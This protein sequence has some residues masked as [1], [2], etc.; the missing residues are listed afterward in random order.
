MPLT[1]KYDVIFGPHKGDIPLAY[2]RALSWGESRLNPLSVHKKSKATGL[3][4]V[5]RVVLDSYNKRHDTKHKL[6]GLTDP[7]LNVKMAS[8]TLNR[9]LRAYRKEG[10]KPNWDSRNW[11]AL[12]TLGWN[13]GYSKKAGL[14][15]VARALRL[16]GTPITL[17]NVAKKAKEMEG[18]VP[19]LSMPRR[20]AW[21]NRVAKKFSTEKKSDNEK[22]LAAKEDIL[23]QADILARRTVSPSVSI[24]GS[25]RAGTTLSLH[26]RAGSDF[27][28]WLAIT[29]GITGIVIYT[30]LPKRGSYSFASQKSRQRAKR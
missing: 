11:V 9:I 21:S 20:L 22:A 7:T 16:E 17:A 15:K 25:R 27:P 26:E 4:Q 1:H 5:T 10:L 6:S 13:A 30:W 23:K 19:Y 18:V 2:M 3:L 14:L 12:F 29:A 28:W 8:E 24:P